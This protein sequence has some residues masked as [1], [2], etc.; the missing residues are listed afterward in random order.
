M[1]RGIEVALRVDSSSL[2]GASK[3]CENL[4]AVQRG[5]TQRGL[6]H[7]RQNIVYNRVWSGVMQRGLDVASRL[8]DSDDGSAWGDAAGQGSRASK[9]KM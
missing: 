7:A 6:V 2:P 5:E 4:L 1:Q 3:C 8:E 9:S